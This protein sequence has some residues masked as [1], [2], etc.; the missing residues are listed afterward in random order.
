M[1]TTIPFNL[2]PHEWPP[3][4]SGEREGFA[5]VV[6]ETQLDEKSVGVMARRVKIPH[7]MSLLFFRC[8][9]DGAPRVVSR[10]NQFPY[11]KFPR[12]DFPPIGPYVKDLVERALQMRQ[13]GFAFRVNMAEMGAEGMGWLYLH[14]DWASGCWMGC[15]GQFNTARFCV[16]PDFGNLGAALL[17]ADSDIR[18]ALD[19]LDSSPGERVRRVVHF[20]NGDLNEMATV[21]RAIALNNPSLPLDSPEWFIGFGT[22]FSFSWRRAPT[23]QWWHRHPDL[24]LRLWTRHLNRYFGL[25]KDEVLAS[26]HACVTDFYPEECVQVRGSIPTQHERLEAALFLREWAKDK[27]PADELRLLLPKL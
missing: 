2:M 9:G 7:G 8:A 5:D 3:L 4:A 6:F 20:A 10:F 11:S 27:I 15:N 14:C 16:E 24:R 12:L 23:W 13:W 26:R 21:V 25:S 18:F 17:N 1:A 19:W 22:H